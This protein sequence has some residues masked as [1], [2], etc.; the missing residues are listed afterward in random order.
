MDHMSW[1]RVSGWFREV[2]LCIQLPIKQ[3]YFTFYILGNVEVK[4]RLDFGGVV[5]F[6]RMYPWQITEPASSWRIP[7]LHIYCGISELSYC[8][9]SMFVDT[10][11]CCICRPFVLTR[12]LCLSELSSGWIERNVNVLLIALCT[13]MPL[14]LCPGKNVRVYFCLFVILY[15]QKLCGY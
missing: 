7:I 2:L 4:Q 11:P 5:N 9:T 15:L 10:H 1:I 6:G 13:Q 8:C 12:L 14:L 3:Q